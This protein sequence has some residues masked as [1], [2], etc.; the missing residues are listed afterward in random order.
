M[1]R[2]FRNSEIKSI[3][4]KFIVVQLI[5]I[6]CLLFFVNFKI[7]SLKSNI[8]RQNTAIIGKIVVKNPSLE[9][10]AIEGFTKEASTEEVKVG[11]KIAKKYDY[12]EKVPLRVVPFFDMF[13]DKFFLNL[14]FIGVI[15]L[16]IIL[17]I[18]FKQYK[19]TFNKINR[20][21]NMAEKAVEGNIEKLNEEGEGDI[22]ILIHNFNNMTNRLKFNIE[23]LGKEKIF[24]KDTISD[25][26]HQ[27]KTPL[28]SLMILNDI[29]LKRKITKEKLM[30]FLQK[31]REQLERMEWLIINLL[32]LAKL[33]AREIQFDL[34]SQ[35][36]KNT[37]YKSIGIL[38][39]KIDKKN[40]SVNVSENN[41]DIE[42]YH[43]YEWLSEAFTNI[44]KNCLEHTNSN[45]KIDIEISETAL[46]TSI[47]I[48]DNG[49]GISKKDLPNI[50]KRFYKS[51]N[52]NSN[53]IG[54]GL[55]LAKSIINGQGGDIK[56]KSKVSEGTEFI[57]TFLK[58][59]I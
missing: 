12:V 3:T 1:N 47:V 36:V 26:S 50:F 20:V 7:N 44:I 57:I 5:F 21:S 37:I 58:N 46:V 6:S 56:V 32:K 17:L 55:S 42:L 59:I 18:V 51:S 43:D 41:K 29:M 38:K 19:S 48:R 31:S 22:A 40:I 28:S 34:S 9:E 14:F 27:L 52:S 10:V 49:E 25:I 8:I 24:L 4:F 11:E 35:C 16:G 2:F 23:N 53:S 13:S 15:N 45:G 30:E 54:I 33:D 39:P